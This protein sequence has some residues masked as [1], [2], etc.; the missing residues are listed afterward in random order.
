MPH[1]LT[2]YIQYNSTAPY[3]AL[4]QCDLLHVPGR[5]GNRERTLEH[6]VVAGVEAV[7]TD[8]RV[9]GVCVLA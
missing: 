7:L 1:V 3:L 4:E 8:I 6:V 2:K 5:V 9:C